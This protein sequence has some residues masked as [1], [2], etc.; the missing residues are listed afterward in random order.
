MLQRG[1]T[2]SSN[3]SLFLTFSGSHRIFAFLFGGV[4]LLPGGLPSSIFF[5]GSSTQGEFSFLSF[6]HK[7]F[8]THRGGI[9]AGQV[10]RAGG[11]GVSLLVLLW[12]RVSFTMSLCFPH[13]HPKEPDYFWF[14]LFCYYFIHSFSGRTRHLDSAS[15][16]ATENPLL[17][18]RGSEPGAAALGVQPE[19]TPAALFIFCTGTAPSLHPA[20]VSRIGKRPQR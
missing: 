4:S 19:P 9:G 14:I 2:V 11:W 10:P 6:C 5:S 7:I 15:D 8:Y 16:R 20:L 3:L 1:L 13:S 12:A 17:L 18:L